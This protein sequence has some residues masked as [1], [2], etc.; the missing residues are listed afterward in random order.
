MAGHSDTDASPFEVFIEPDSLPVFVEERDGFEYRIAPRF[1]HGKL[2]WAVRVTEGNRVRYE[3]ITGLTEDA[4]AEFGVDASFREQLNDLRKFVHRKFPQL[5]VQGNRQ[6]IEY[7]LADAA[8][9][10]DDW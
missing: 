2:R 10:K 5:P 8:A 4:A 3:D 6:L 9:L 7:P 1:N